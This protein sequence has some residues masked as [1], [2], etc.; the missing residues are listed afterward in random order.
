MLT[1]LSSGLGSDKGL[2]TTLALRS[3]SVACEDADSVEDGNS[4]P[5]LVCLW[6]RAQLV[7]PSQL[8]WAGNTACSPLPHPLSFH[9]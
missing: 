2:A 4:G 8:Y 3:G 5:D 9:V 7:S 6:E 1:G